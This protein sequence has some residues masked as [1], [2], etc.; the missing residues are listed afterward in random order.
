[1]KYSE[2]K[3]TQ[4]L[5]TGNVTITIKDFDTFVKTQTRK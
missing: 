1:M 2:I 3:N 4:T 5:P